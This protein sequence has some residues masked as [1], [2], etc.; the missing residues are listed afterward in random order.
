MIHKNHTVD[1]KGGFGNVQEKGGN[2]TRYRTV[3]A[4][5]GR[6]DKHALFVKVR[7]KFQR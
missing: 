7:F 2:P 4:V 6:V 3:F 5:I 1:P